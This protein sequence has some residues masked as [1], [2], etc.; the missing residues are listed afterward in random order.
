M[1]FVGFI[2]Y[3]FLFYFFI[4]KIKSLVV[5]QHGTQG[6]IFFQLFKM[7]FLANPPPSPPPT[8]K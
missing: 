3:L 4:R 8:H 7:E 2:I 5:G 6:F 1:V